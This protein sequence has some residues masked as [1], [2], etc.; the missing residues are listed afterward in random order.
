MPTHR[1][2]PIEVD[3]IHWNGSVSS[4]RDVEEWARLRTVVAHHTFS[5]ETGQRII[6]FHPDGTALYA[7]V[8]D[9]I[10]HSPLQVLLQPYPAED[11]ERVFEPIPE[12]PLLDL[13]HVA[14]ARALLDQNPMDQ[15]PMDL[16]IFPARARHAADFPVVVTAADGR[17]FTA[18]DPALATETL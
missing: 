11:F 4:T 15:N 5:E 1:K 9:Y 12:V 2:K 3:A 8:G 7:F 16:P 10:V 18:I 13:P 14:A 17:T 6:L